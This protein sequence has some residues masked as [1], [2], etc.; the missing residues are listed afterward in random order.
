M[1]L[2][3]RLKSNNLVQILNDFWNVNTKSSAFKGSFNIWTFYSYVYLKAWTSEIQ[4]TYLK[5]EL[6]FVCFLKPDAL[7][8]DVHWRECAK[9]EL[10]WFSGRLT[11]VPS[12]AVDF[13]YRLNRNIFVQI[14]DKKSSKIV[15]LQ[16][17]TKC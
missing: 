3:W 8:S 9:F 6:F 15:T 2:K 11:F 5:L 13:R 1:D 12:Q 16:L 7:F 10:I 17:G 14:S 4:T